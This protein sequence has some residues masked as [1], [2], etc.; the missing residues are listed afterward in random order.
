LWKNDIDITYIFRDSDYSTSF[1]RIEM[2][3]QMDTFALKRFEAIME[4]YREYFDASK[5]NFMFLERD[6]EFDI[7]LARIC[8]DFAFNSEYSPSTVLD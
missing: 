4:G 8:L 1:S 7:E 6:D 3:D 2:P 5:E